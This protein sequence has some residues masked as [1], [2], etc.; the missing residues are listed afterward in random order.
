MT[1]ADAL[2]DVL[3]AEHA[4]VAVFASFLGR[5]PAP[6]PLAAAV[7]AAYAE[8]R[9]RRDELTARLRAAGEEPVVAAPTYRLPAPLR[10]VR[11]VGVAAQEAERA[12]SQAYAA[13]VAL[14]TEE[15]RSWAVSALTASALRAVTLGDRPAAFPGAPELG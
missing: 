3:A 9:G 2:Q 12:A 13:L 15:T 14:T 10:T 6:S 5:L 11:Q 1:D 4:A 7:S 8:H